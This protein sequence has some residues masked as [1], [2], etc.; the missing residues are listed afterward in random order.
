[1]K[2]IFLL[3]FLSAVYSSFGIWR[4]VPTGTSEN[5][6]KIE[7]V[8][9][10]A[11]CVG[12]N[13]TV[14][15][16]T[17][18]GE[19]WT[20]ISTSATGN[21]NAIKFVNSTTG[22]FTTSDGYIFK[23]SNSGNSWTGTE[24]HTGGIN[25]IDFL[26]SSIGIAVGDNGFIF[27][28]TNGGSSWSSLGSISVFT[29]TG[30]AAITESIAV[31]VGTQGSYLVSEDG[32]EN[33]TYKS[34][35]TTVAFSKVEKTSNTT[36]IAVGSGGHIAEFS[37]TSLTLSNANKIDTE[38]DWIKDIFVRDFDGVSRPVVVGFASSIYVLN[39]GWKTWDIDSVNNLN[40]LHF[41]NDT[42]GITCGF[43]GKIYKTTSGAV[44]NSIQK[45][46]RENI[47]LHPNPTTNTVFLNEELLN[48][49]ASIYALNGQLVY[50]NVISSL[51]LDVSFLDSGIYFL[52]F[53][54]E[55]KLY[56][57][58]IIKK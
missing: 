3:I 58:R 33:W 51:A 5:L 7:I 38:D 41:Y 43:N 49:N 56:T 8:N 26:T 47:Q 25:G 48:T 40:G 54:A 16:S 44:P 2:N 57:S 21:I 28:T 52:K 14:L 10:I 19:S 11:F 12:D 6:N 23:T 30:V 50:N 17:D 37:T 39:G 9:D 24:I 36:A 27:R 55:D 4:E 20:S 45:I 46:K 18:E 29:I 32:G 1:M 53:R 13:G 42:I 31:A 15:K 22:F 34:I 35:A